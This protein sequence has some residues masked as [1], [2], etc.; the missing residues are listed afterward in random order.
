MEKKSRPMTEKRLMNIALHYLERFESSGGHLRQ[1]L[2]NRVFKEKTKGTDIAHDVENVISAIVE[3][4][5]KL[6]YVDDD[7][8]AKNLVERL[9]SSGKSMRFIKQKLAQASI[10]PETISKTLEAYEEQNQESEYAAACRFARK[11]RLGI[12]RD[13]EKQ[14]LF[15]KK[16][17]ASMARA[18]FSFEVAVKALKHN[19]DE[20]LQ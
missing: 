9:K 5:Q 11:K 4:V 19:S 16:D 17:L 20:E 1:I 15:R 3:K 2:K 6:G 7:R 18:G 14:A 8:F 13:P 12:Y 10:D